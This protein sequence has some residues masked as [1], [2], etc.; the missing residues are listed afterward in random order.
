MHLTPQ[1]LSWNEFF[2]ELLEQQIALRSKKGCFINLKHY[3]QENKI[4]KISLLFW[5]GDSPSLCIGVMHMDA[6]LNYYKVLS[7]NFS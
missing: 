2:I 4:K 3:H 7:T 1:K 6:L 5:K